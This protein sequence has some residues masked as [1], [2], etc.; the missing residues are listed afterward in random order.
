MSGVVRVPD[1]VLNG[2]K[3]VAG[4]RGCQPGEVLADAWAEYFANH[5][6]E[7]ANDLEEAARLLRAGTL[8]D[9]AA[10]LGRGNEARAEEAAAR[11]R[12]K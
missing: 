10:F 3:H 4:I 2:A 6:D 5:Q 12:S 1:N 7:F 11:L 8:D 9:L